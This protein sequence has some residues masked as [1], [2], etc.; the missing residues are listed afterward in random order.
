[1]FLPFARSNC[2]NPCN[3]CFIL[4]LYSFCLVKSFTHRRN[5]NQLA[6]MRLHFFYYM[7][8]FHQA[9]D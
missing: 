5:N 2:F 9:I 3:N 8:A 4:S 7:A 1:M 6:I